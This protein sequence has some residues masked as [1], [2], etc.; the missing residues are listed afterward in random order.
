MKL[1]HPLV[2]FDLETTGV[3]IEQDKIVEI[4]IIKLSPDGSK[5]V[6]HKLVNPGIPIPPIVS[7]LIGIKDSD[8][9]DAPAFK[10]I[11]K[12]LLSL[13]MML[14]SADLM[15]KDLICHY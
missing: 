8:V 9:Q 7:E 10:E 4:A 1:T 13:L 6:Y 3:W 2:V 15:W 12:K 11:A 14:I 5:E